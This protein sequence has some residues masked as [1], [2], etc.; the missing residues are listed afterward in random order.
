VQLKLPLD[1]SRVTGYLVLD[2]LDGPRTYRPSGINLS[3][4]FIQSVYCC[5]V[6]TGAELRNAETVLA[7]IGEWFDMTTPG[8]P[9][10]HSGCGARRS[11]GQKRT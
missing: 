9:T 7:Q 6:R 1:L 8:R 5:K 2:V 4:P 3:N 10:R 11:T